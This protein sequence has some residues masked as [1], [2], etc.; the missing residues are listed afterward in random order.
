MIEI[1]DESGRVNFSYD[2]FGRVTSETGEIGVIK[3][4]YNNIGLLSGKEC[5]FSR[6]DATTQSF[7]TT[8]SYDNFDRIT[9]V[10]SPAGTYS[11][12]YDNKG[13]VASLSSSTPGGTSSTS[14]ASFTVNYSYDKAGRLVSKSFSPAVNGL[15]GEALAK[16]GERSTENGTILCSYE[17][18]KLDRRVKS[19]V[20]GVK[21]SYGYDNFNQLTSAS[22]S[23]GYIYGYDFDKIGNRLV[24]RNGATA[25][26]YKYNTLNQ[27]CSVSSVPSVGSPFVYDAYGNLTKSQDAEYVY[28]L[29]NRLTEVKKPNVTV[30][31][32]YDPLGQ[33]IK[34]EIKTVNGEQSTVNETKFLMSGMVEQA[35]M[36][37]SVAQFHTFGLDLVQSLTSTGGVGAVLSST[38]YCSLSPNPCTLSYLYDGNG[39]VIAVADSTGSI[40]AKLTY[41]PFGEK[42]SGAD[43]P[44]TFSTK[45]S[46]SSGLS[47]YGHRF[48]N[49]EIGRWLSR[50]PIGERENDIISLSKHKRNNFN[51]LYGFV[52]N[53]PIN[54]WDYIG[55]LLGQGNATSVDL[56]FSSLDAQNPSSFDC[57]DITINYD[58][59]E[60]VTDGCWWTC[61][62]YSGGP[63]L[64]SLPNM[65]SSIAS[66][67]NAPSCSNFDC[68]TETGHLIVKDLKIVVHHDNDCDCAL[69]YSSDSIT[70]SAKKCEKKK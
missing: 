27:I 34:S 57:V 36:T 21:W 17:Y 54:H 37:D 49:P 39:N 59:Y 7:K 6:S 31:Y 52:S 4:E 38:S 53:N 40:T 29:H 16:S 23:D 33:R 61:L 63:S 56:Y 45:A 11:Y 41:S 1:S 19:E 35:R 50:D 8:Y 68:C 43:L 22:S 60:T 20:N 12:K 67:L 28:D 32:G 26:S 44:F 48:Y 47:Y 15:P 18:D 25:Q 58:H 9:M 66:F 64:S 70:A 46:D 62:Q 51:I 69:F 3:Y 24:S 14:S 65:P 10:S 5:L 30:K 2:S 42:L 55:L 13:R